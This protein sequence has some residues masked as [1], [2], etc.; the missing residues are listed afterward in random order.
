M[1]YSATPPLTPSPT[2]RSTCWVLGFAITAT[3]L[4]T[5]DMSRVTGGCAY[6]DAGLCGLLRPVASGIADL[7]L[8]PFDRPRALV[9]ADRTMRR[10]ISKSRATYNPSRRV[11]M[12]GF[13]LWHVAVVWRAAIIGAIAQKCRS[14]ARNPNVAVS[15]PLAWGGCLACWSGRCGKG[16][17]PMALTLDLGA[18]GC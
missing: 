9:G 4:L 14:G 7:H 16:L 1:A 10:S 12:D 18:G 13:R 15:V 2:A 11:D 6:A 5:H 3:I 8:V 17:P